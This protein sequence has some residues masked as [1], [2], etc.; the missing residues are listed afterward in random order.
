MSNREITSPF[1]Q[2]LI[3]PTAEETPEK[4]A[5]NSSPPSSDIDEKV[6]NLSHAQKLRKMHKAVTQ[7]LRKT[8]KTKEHL[9]FLRKE[10]EVTCEELKNETIEAK[11]QSEI[12][13]LSEISS[14]ETNGV[15]DEVKNLEMQIQRLKEKV[16]VGE[17]GIKSR[18]SQADEIKE[19]IFELEHYHNSREASKTCECKTCL[20]I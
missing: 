18:K 8:Q 10:V 11:H 5:E 12:L 20:I 14:R 2:D 4:T 3:I 6:P 9:K 13:D 15:W 17:E 19:L 1:H 16:R 7:I